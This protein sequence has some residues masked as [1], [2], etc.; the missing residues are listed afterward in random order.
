MSPGKAAA[1]A[2]HASM[3]LNGNSKT[4]FVS[5]Y[6]RTVI[7]LEAKNAQQIINLYVYLDNIDM[8]C[9]YYIDEGKNEVD[10]YSVTALAIGPIEYDDTE[11]REMFEA[12]PLFSEDRK[13]I[14]ST[15]LGDVM[16]FSGDAK[17][18]KS[19]KKV[20]KFL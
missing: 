10:A 3:M 17:H 12:F 6:K 7:I 15:Y 14:A 18:R 19:V 2:V 13:A 11:K 9:S 16:S 1:Q 5:D 8:D 20:L 4:D